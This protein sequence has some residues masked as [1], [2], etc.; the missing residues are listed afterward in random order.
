ML[1]ST[2][3]VI[4]VYWKRGACAELS[5]TL[6][7]P[8]PLTCTLSVCSGWEGGAYPG[9]GSDLSR[10]RHRHLCWLTDL[11]DLVRLVSA[12]ERMPCSAADQRPTPP[13]R[14]T[15]PHLAA[16]MSL[17]RSHSWRGDRNGQPLPITA[18]F[19]L[20]SAP[21]QPAISRPTQEIWFF[22]SCVRSI[23]KC[24]MKMHISLVFLINI[25]CIGSMLT[26]C[27]NEL[28]GKWTT[29]GDKG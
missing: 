19:S 24:C 17:L 9:E 21:H 7:P 22:F 15:Q 5:L 3:I 20:T 2:D 14:M 1:I 13:L 27:L 11:H 28:C 6:G 18:R 23:Q 26:V 4:H 10:S 16:M 8:A 25:L 29:Q 12:G